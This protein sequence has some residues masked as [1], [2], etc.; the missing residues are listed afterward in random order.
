M[1]VSVV[2]P[3]HN[4]AA[5]IRTTLEGLLAH[6]SDPC[7]IIVVA[8]HCTDATEEIA[9]SI[10]LRDK[11]VRVLRNDALPRGFGNTVATGLRAATGDCV[12]PFMADC[13]D[14]PATVD[15]LR[16][17]LEREH[18]DVVCASRYMPGGRKTGG[19][20]LQNILSRVVSAALH[21]VARVPTHDV[22]NAFKMYRTTFLRGIDFALPGSGTE[23]SLGVLLRAWRAGAAIGEIPTIWTG[24]PIPMAREWRILKRFPGYWR[25][26]RA[27]FGR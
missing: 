15:R 8:D 14:D 27:A 6:V 16:D 1:N 17:A 9:A 7:E 24:K 20:M 11:R 19:P 4:E 22:A 13:C 12:V 25:W 21:R 18:L 10:A 26:V 3:A 23:Y 5:N 2:I